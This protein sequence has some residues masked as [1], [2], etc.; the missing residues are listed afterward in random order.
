MSTEF[1]GV[2]REEDPDSS[3]SLQVWIL[4]DQSTPE[5]AWRNAW[6]LEMPCLWKPSTQTLTVSWGDVSG[7][8]E[9]T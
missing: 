9:C 5:P 7:M 3:L 2:G 8:R 6:I 1:V 4:L